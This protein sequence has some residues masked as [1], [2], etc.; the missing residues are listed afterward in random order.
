[1]L[2]LPR[3]RNYLIRGKFKRTNDGERPNF[4]EENENTPFSVAVASQN[5]EGIFKPVK[6]REINQE[7]VN[8]YTSH[9]SQK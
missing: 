7:M 3:K 4:I 6:R 8:K 1:M 9:I 2:G 5:Q